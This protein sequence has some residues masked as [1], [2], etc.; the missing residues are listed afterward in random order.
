MSL[1]ILMKLY[2]IRLEEISPYG[3]CNDLISW[4]GS[5]FRDILHQV[6]L[7]YNV[8]LL[9]IGA[10]SIRWNELEI[11]QTI[12]CINNSDIDIIF[13]LMTDHAYEYPPTATEEQNIYKVISALSKPV[14]FIVWNHFKNEYGQ[15]QIKYP[16]WATQ[17][18]SFKKKINDS[19]YI[20]YS[21]TNI[22]STSKKYLYSSLS[23]IIYGFRLVNLVEFQKSNYYDKSLIVVNTPNRDSNDKL[24]WEWEMQL[25][26]PAYASAFKEI[27]PT[28]PINTA[29]SPDDIVLAN[30]VI[31]ED[32]VYDYN[33][34][35]YTNSYVNLI[36]ESAYELPFFSEKT[37]K[38]ILANQFFVIIGGKG[39]IAVLREMGIDTYDDIIDHSIYDNEPHNTRIQ[40][41]HKLL[42]NMQY[43][44]WEQIY[45]DTVE[46]REKNRQF[47]L[48]KP[49]EKKFLL[50]LEQMITAINVI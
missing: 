30:G 47:L 2:N 6:N 18:V 32:I 34:A 15:Y 40:A 23:N 12:T 28:L 19:D 49:F 38:P 45:K 17:C 10:G 35:A 13:F 20:Y 4:Q 33:N 26:W 1:N 29:T 21:D 25:R 11:N 16:F 27:L 24:F 7:N 39:S 8:C 48:E 43:Y 37:F 50:E 44:D 22:T 31:N 46:R 14:I 41:I 42:H 36:I 9:D 5:I 3:I